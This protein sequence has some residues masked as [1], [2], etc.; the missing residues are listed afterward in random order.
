MGG[1][2]IIGATAEAVSGRDRIS[3][4][5]EQSF[6]DGKDNTNSLLTKEIAKIVPKILRKVRKLLEAVMLGSRLAGRSGPRRWTR[7]RAAGG[8]LICLPVAVL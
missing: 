7:C 4:P 8:L 5:N 6:K 1:G 2:T 3:P